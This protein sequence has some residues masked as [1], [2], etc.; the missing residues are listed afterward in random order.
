MTPNSGIDDIIFQGID[1]PY[2]QRNT[3]AGVRIQPAAIG[4]TG[5]LNLPQVVP[6]PDKV[7]T[8]V[9]KTD[10]KEIMGPGG[11]DGYFPFSHSLIAVRTNRRFS[12]RHLQPPVRTEKFKWLQI[13][14]SGYL[15]SRQFH[16]GVPDNQRIKK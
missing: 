15:Q 9:V 8:L 6:S 1:G 16:L 3:F 11:V 12:M 7:G 14:K 10:V 4:C 5:L 13:R 2:G